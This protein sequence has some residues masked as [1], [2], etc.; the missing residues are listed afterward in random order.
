MGG[1]S[2]FLSADPQPVEHHR[3][4]YVASIKHGGIG[5]NVR[6]APTPCADLT[7]FHTKNQKRCWPNQPP[8]PIVIIDN[9]TCQ[10]PYIGL[11][12]GCMYISTVFVQGNLGWLPIIRTLSWSKLWAVHFSAPNPGFF[13]RLPVFQAN[14]VRPDNIR[15]ADVLRVFR[16]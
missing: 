1:E 11:H 7:T 13:L 3:G 14:I 5:A 2:L 4:M 9:R 12:R 8:L 16:D 15:T 10:P 6:M